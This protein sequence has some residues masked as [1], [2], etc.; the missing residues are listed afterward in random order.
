MS[1][2]GVKVITNDQTI[3]Q[4][5]PDGTENDVEELSGTRV[6]KNKPDQGEMDLILMT[7]SKAMMQ[8]EYIEEPTPEKDDDQNERKNSDDDDQIEIKDDVNQNTENNENDQENH[9]DSK[10]DVEESP[11][12]VHE[13]PKSQRPNT[14]N[15]NRRRYPQR[16]PYTSRP[17]PKPV[18]ASSE[19]PCGLA[20]EFFNGATK[21]NA[22]SNTLAQTVVELENRRDEQI[23]NGNISE[24]MNFQRAIETAKIAQKESC[25]RESQ[26]Q[27]LKNIQQKKEQVETDYRN[28]QREMKEKEKELHQKLNEYIENIETKQ[29]NEMEEHDK[30]WQSELCQRRYN[31]SSQQLRTLRLQ[32]FQLFTAKRFADSDQ[33]RDIANK[34]EKEETQESFRHM[35]KDFSDSRKTLETKQKEEMDMAITVTKRRKQE[36]RYFFN[37]KKKPYI[38]RLQNLAKEEAEVQANPEGLWNLKHRFDGNTM[39]NA[40]G[41][42]SPRSTKIPWQNNVADYNTLKLPPLPTPHSKQQQQQEVE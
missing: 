33:V 25:K 11:I 26:Q 23:S 20:D 15:N 7:Q 19:D 24:S 32:Q 39:S 36:F 41:Q 31:R 17:R 6:P 10:G 29:K 16:R 42:Q 35:L 38:Q 18:E 14:I 3:F 9:E 5:L 22:D 40:G 13:P 27:A 28:M 34:L 30:K 2:P 1:K 4:N 37:S 8:N 21:S 12:E